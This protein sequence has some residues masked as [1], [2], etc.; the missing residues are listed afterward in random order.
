MELVKQKD[1]AIEINPVSN[2]VLKLVEDY[3]NHPGTTLLSQNFPLVVSSDD[4]Q[5]WE[6]TPLTHDFY[7]AFLG[8]TPAPS[9]LRTLKKLAK[10]SIKY[11]A[12][13]DSEKT[14]AL[15]KWQPK[16]DEFIA[17]LIATERNDTG[18]SNEWLASCIYVAAATIVPL[19]SNHL[20][21]L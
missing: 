20:Y 18:G 9:D 5:F 6:A 15:A 13:T 10:N 1:I 14:K 7:M 11:S 2:Q 17:N 4:P 12:L 21:L 8:M 16:W 3:R 19:A